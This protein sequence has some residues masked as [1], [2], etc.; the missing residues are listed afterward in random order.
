MS[1]NFRYFASRLMLRWMIDEEYA[2]GS[3]FSKIILTKFDKI[4]FRSSWHQTMM[5]KQIVG[6]DVQLFLKDRISVFFSHPK[7]A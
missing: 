2:S 6:G 1:Y 7:G 3:I 4:I 5:L